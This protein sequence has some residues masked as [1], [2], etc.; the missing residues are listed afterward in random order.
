[1]WKYI[2]LGNDRSCVSVTERAEDF[3]G[4]ILRLAKMIITLPFTGLLRVLVSH[5]VLE[6]VE[7]HPAFISSC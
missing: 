3:K 1:M 7:E 5:T 6:D 4:G 2:G